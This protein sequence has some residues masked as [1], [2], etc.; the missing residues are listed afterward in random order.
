MNIILWVNFQNF[1]FLFYFS[2]VNFAKLFKDLAVRNVQSTSLNLIHDEE[3]SDVNQDVVI[4]PM[5]IKAYKVV[6]K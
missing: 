6:M 4:P 5:E 2:Q 1:F 3:K